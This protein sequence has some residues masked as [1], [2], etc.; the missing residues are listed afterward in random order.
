M[1]PMRQR[2]H[3]WRTISRTVDSFVAVFIVIPSSH[4]SKLLSYQMGGVPLP[5]HTFLP[6]DEHADFVII[7]D[8]T[9]KEVVE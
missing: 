9:G 4:Q 8:Y 3:R 5:A 7:C 6:V 1:F 2:G